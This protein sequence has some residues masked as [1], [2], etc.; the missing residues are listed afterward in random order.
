MIEIYKSFIDPSILSIYRSK[1]YF[2]HYDKEVKACKLY[3]DK[4]ILIEL[5][6][7]GNK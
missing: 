4:K 1:I 2:L 5:I 3:L 7:N 6:I